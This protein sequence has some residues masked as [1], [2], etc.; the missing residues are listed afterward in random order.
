M[1]KPAVDA[2]LNIFQRKMLI[3]RGIPIYQIFALKIAS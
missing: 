1:P 3:M 2:F